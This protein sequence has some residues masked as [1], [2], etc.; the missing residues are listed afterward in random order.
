LPG[1]HVPYIYCMKFHCLF[2]LQV[3][4]ATI[5]AKAQ[6]L[7][8]SDDKS[9]HY[10][11]VAPGHHYERATRFDAAGNVSSEWISEYVTKID[12][13]K[14]ELLFVRF[15]PYAIGRFSMDSCVNNSKGPLRYSLVTYPAT[16][17][18]TLTY[19]PTA[20]NSHLT[21]KGIT[22]DKATTMAE[23]YFDDTSIWELF[24]VMTLQKGEKYYLN[25]YGS[26][27]QQPVKYY[28]EYSMDDYLTGPVGPAISPGSPA[29]NPGS[30]A[31]NSGGSSIGCQVIA[32]TYDD[33]SW[34]V[35]VDPGTHRV[36][37]KLLQTKESSMV[38][39]TL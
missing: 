8:R 3:L 27:Q 38:M 6:T 36:L 9:I 29:T 4:L 37:K 1:D 7:L 13:D 16:K 17:L 24:A 33:H 32:I 28:I 25:V 15:T 19:S 11:W 31:T 14:K 23:G 30:P 2:L 20:I 26:D 5:G 39:M 10:E 35:W 22:T 12:K 21:R 18:E 34:H